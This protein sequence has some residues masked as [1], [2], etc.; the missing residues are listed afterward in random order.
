MFTVFSSCLAYT[1]FIAS[2]RTN[3]LDTNYTIINVF[4]INKKLICFPSSNFCR[5]KF[6]GEIELNC[7]YKFVFFLFNY[8]LAYQNTYHFSKQK[9]QTE[10]KIWTMPQ[11]AGYKVLPNVL[12]IHIRDLNTIGRLLNDRNCKGQ[13]NGRRLAF[14]AQYDILIK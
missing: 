14:L 11:T 7:L 9:A 3:E 5:L 8:T 12:F 2:N 10:Y 4:S 13:K 1:Y 6:V